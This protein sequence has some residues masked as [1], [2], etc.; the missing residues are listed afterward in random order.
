MRT[1][2]GNFLIDAWRRKPT[3]PPAPISIDA[4]DAEGRYLNEPADNVTPEHL[5]DRAWAIT[6]LNRVLEL[7]GEHYAASDRAELFG[8][9][10]VVLTEGKGAVRSWCWPS[11]WA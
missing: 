4:R 2:C 1:A 6:L 11:G 5:F 3:G 10:K 8:E 9:L 7:L